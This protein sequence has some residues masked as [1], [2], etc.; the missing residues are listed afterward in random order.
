MTNRKC[1]DCK[2]D[3]ID[4]FH[5]LMD[6]FVSLSTNHMT[7]Q[8]IALFAIIFW[9]FYR[10]FNPSKQ[11][12]VI[13]EMLEQ[14]K[15]SV[16]ESRL[17]SHGFFSKLFYPFYVKFKIA[18]FLGAQKHAER[19]K[20]LISAGIYNTEPEDLQLAGVSSAVIVAI[21]LLFVGAAFFREHFVF[22]FLGTLV[23]SIFLYY[24]PLLDVMGKKTI[25]EEKLL[26]D[27][28]QLV[29]V[30]LM[31]VSGNDTPD[32]AL[33]KAI[34]KLEGRLPAL[35][36]YL[37]NL[38][39]ALE[40]K[41]TKEAVE[42]FAAA[43]DKTYADRFAAN[44]NMAIKHAG[45]DQ[46]AINLRLRETLRELQDEIADKKINKMKASARIPSYVSMAAIFGYMIVI[47]IYIVL[48]TL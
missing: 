24:S 19:K 46:S 1:G 34:V 3:I 43:L 48:A 5:Q 16:Q 38:N 22:V 39:V 13:N 30:Y 10:L 11:R 37:K 29:T 45:G 20:L 47:V 23:I 17:V 26:G 25:H 35:S 33:K 9:L 18:S 4:I 21:V 15:L 2:L 42:D 31:Q 7:Y 28:V 6:L 14:D 27:F 36:Y 12:K 41:S 44:V 8:V 32:V 40:A